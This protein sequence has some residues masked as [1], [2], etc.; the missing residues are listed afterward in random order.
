MALVQVCS[1][2]LAGAFIANPLPGGT[3]RLSGD[4]GR[5]KIGPSLHVRSSH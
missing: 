5:C 2:D 3:G 1:R 4:V